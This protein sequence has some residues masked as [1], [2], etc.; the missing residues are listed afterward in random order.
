MAK[1]RCK[2]V[3]ISAGFPYHINDHIETVQDQ[4][5]MNTGSVQ[6][7]WVGPGSVPGWFWVGLLP[8]MISAESGEPANKK[9][10]GRRAARIAR[11]KR[12]V[13]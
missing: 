8:V 13:E 10:P 6:D 7:P 12:I 4:Y 2:R 5:R 11:V 9:N 3:G 1:L